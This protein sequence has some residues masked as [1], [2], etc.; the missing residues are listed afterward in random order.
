M[1][2]DATPCD[3]RP[4]QAERRMPLGVNARPLGLARA[5]AARDRR[6]GDLRALRPDRHRAAPGSALAHGDSPRFRSSRSRALR[7]RYRPIDAPTERRLSL[8]GVAAR[9]ALRHLDRLAAARERRRLDAARL[10]VADLYR[11]LVA[12]AHAR[13]ASARGRRDRAGAGRR[14]DRGRH[15]E[16]DRDRRSASGSRS[17]ARSRWPRTCSS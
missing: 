7:G 15:A 8:A 9:R 11:N 10:L 5:R 14:R 3:A 12:R 17:A 13:V 2:N 1:S 4:C 16:P 6:R